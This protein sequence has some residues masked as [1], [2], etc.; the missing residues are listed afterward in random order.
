MSIQTRSNTELLAILVGKRKADKL[1]NHTL[2]S[3]FFAREGSCHYIKELAAAKELV[4][5]SL[6]E[7]IQQLDVLSSPA[8][9]SEYL[10][11]M[12]RGYEHEVFVT[13]FLDTQNRLI[14]TEELFR[15]TLTNTAVY[16]REVVKRALFLNAGNVIFAH[17]HPSGLATPSHADK[18]LTETLKQA[19]ALVDVKVL[20]HLVIGD[21]VAVS[22]AESGWL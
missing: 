15:G 2:T 10:K 12:L 11:L 5:R 18:L 17:N 9:V 6:N 20:D 13:L 8:K 21:T 16:P 14:S 7:E 22:F 19:L 3:L 1:Y 4:K